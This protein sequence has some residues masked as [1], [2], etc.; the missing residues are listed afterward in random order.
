MLI[1][2][3]AAEYGWFIDETPQDDT[4]FAIYSDLSNQMDLLTVVMHELGHVFGLEDLTSEA[5][6]TDLMFDTL[7]VGVRR[8]ETRLPAKTTIL[9]RPTIQHDAHFSREIRRQDP[10]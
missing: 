1:D 6:R 2:I 10:S 9:P 5:D 3:N 8:I 7:S 4:E